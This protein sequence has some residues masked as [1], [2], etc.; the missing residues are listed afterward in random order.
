MHGFELAISLTKPSLSYRDTPKYVFYYNKRYQLDPL[1]KISKKLK[2]N[3]RKS[4]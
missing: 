1:W 3:E 2:N 4:I